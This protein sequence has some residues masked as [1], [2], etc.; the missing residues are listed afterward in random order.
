M[1]NSSHSWYVYSWDLNGGEIWSETALFYTDAFPEPPM[2]FATIT[3]ENNAEGIATE[4]EF[5]WNETDD[6]DPVEELHYQLVYA[7]DWADSST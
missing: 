4:V 1:D 7:T 3:P 2:N 5:V 6:P